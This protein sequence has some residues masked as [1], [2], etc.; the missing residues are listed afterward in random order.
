MPRV[1][2]ISALVI[3]APSQCETSMTSWPDTP[4]KKY[5]LPPEKPTTSCGNTGP[6]HQRHVVLDDRPVEPHR[7]PSWR[8]RPSDSSASRSAPMVPTV[9]ERRRIPPLVIAH[10]HPRIG[11]RPARRAG[12]RGAGPAPPRSS[13]ACVPSAMSTVSRAHPAVQRLV[14]GPEQQRQRAAAGAVR[15]D[16]RRRCGR[17]GRRRR[18]ARGR[19]RGSARPRARHRARR[20]AWRLRSAGVCGGVCVISP[21]ITALLPPGSTLPTPAGWCNPRRQHAA[22]GCHEPARTCP[23]CQPMTTPGCTR[24]HPDRLLPAE[25]GVRAIAPRLYD[26]VRDLPIISPHGHVDPRLLLDDEPFR[27]PG[28]PVRDTRPLRDP[29][30]A[31]QRRPAGRA[32]GGRGAAARRPRPAQVWRLLCAHWDV[33][34]GTPVRYWLE[35]EL[36]DIFERRRAAVGARPP[37]RIYDQIAERLA[38][39]AYRPRAL[40]ERFGIEVLATTD[41]PARRPVGARRARRRPD[42]V[43]AGD[44]DLPAGPLPRAGRARLAGRDRAPRRGRRPST[45]ATTPGYVRRAGGAAPLLHR[46]RRRLGRPQPRRRPHRSAG[47]AE[48]ARIYRAGAGRRGDRGGVG[49]IP[50]AH[51]AGDGPDVL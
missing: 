13:R 28:Q 27:R 20:S 6:D 4:G 16:R 50:P 10:R 8:S 29:A 22:T 24:L 15:H 46:A 38:K 9:G 42:A 26:A 43:R 11:A 5:L 7:R 37:T 48:A 47:A 39:D 2:M 35:A 45:P 32:R 31:R 3:S 36:A 12:S 17:P 14:H 1:P 30:A 41:D 51:A 18:A 44:P 23:P 34:R 21:L 25:P 49:G 19:I 33:Y 40:Y